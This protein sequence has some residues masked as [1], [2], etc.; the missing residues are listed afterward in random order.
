MFFM[1]LEYP[2]VAKPTVIADYEDYQKMHHRFIVSYRALFEDISAFSLLPEKF[3]TEAEPVIDHFLNKLYSS[4]TKSSDDH[5]RLKVVVDFITRF[6]EF[7][8]DATDMFAKH[9]SLTNKTLHY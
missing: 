1:I 7:M 3:I 6:H 2:K 4:A 5:I 8:D 9:Q